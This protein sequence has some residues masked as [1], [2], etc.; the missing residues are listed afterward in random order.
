MYN[1]EFR[2]IVAASGSSDIDETLVSNLVHINQQLLCAIGVSHRSLDSICH[3]TRQL[4]D[5][6]KCTTKLTGAGGGGCAYTL[7][8]RIRGE[9][10]IDFLKRMDQVQ[11]N[12]ERVGAEDEEKQWKFKCFTSSVGSAGVLWLQ[13]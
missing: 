13:R 3:R 4:Y 5:R 12:I 9:S 10:N 1:R 2:D 6:M 8:E 11:V 7:V